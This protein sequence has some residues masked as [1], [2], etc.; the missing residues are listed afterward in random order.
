MSVLVQIFGSLRTLK[1]SDKTDKSNVSGK[2]SSYYEE[3]II[4]A[5]DT[6]EELLAINNLLSY[7]IPEIN[8]ENVEAD[9]EQY[10]WNFNVVINFQD[11]A[12]G[13]A[14]YSLEVRFDHLSNVII[15]PQ[16]CATLTSIRPPPLF[17][18]IFPRDTTNPEQ[19]LILKGTFKN[20][21]I[22]EGHFQLYF[23]LQD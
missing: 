22:K 7:P 13:F 23:E 16:S 6:K 12:I 1:F 4:S 18:T 10:N 11:V 5:I 2:L 21:N 15:H 9:K 8:C 19:K 14:F 20:R 3:K 17:D